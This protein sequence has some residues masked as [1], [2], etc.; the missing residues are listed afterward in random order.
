[1][2]V[3]CN[4]GCRMGAVGDRK[5]IRCMQ[6]PQLGRLDKLVFKSAGDALRQKKI[7]VIGAGPAGLEAACRLAECG[8]KPE[9]Y[10]KEAR[11]GGLANLAAI[12]PHKENMARVVS[13]RVAYL[14]QRHVPIH[15][16]EAY[17]LE[18]A[19]S[20]RPDFLFA[21]T[22]GKP[23]IPKLPGID[24]P[25]VVSGDDVLRGNVPDGKRIAVLGG[26]LIGCETAEY[27]ATYRHKDVEIMEMREDVA[28]DL[29]KS[30]RSFM[31]KRMSD[32]GIKLHVNVK[33]KELALPDI[34][35]EDASGVTAL[36]GFDGVV[37]AFGRRAERGLID[38]LA[39]SDF[40]GKVY[41]IGDAQKPSFAIDAISGAAERVA[42]F[43]KEN[44]E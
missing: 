39:E 5:M 27:L 14:E 38:Q 40:N 44:D 7:V 1:M 33:V 29:V 19:L 43:M 24:G 36:H 8:L 32:L 21:A 11:P 25:G 6:N 15:Y 37:V 30:R 31:L 2:C 34:L 12:P 13:C 41:E 9:V 4:Q 18:K 16:G 20:E 10:E 26:G 17:T 22:G 42:D 28:I 23:L 35:V 3:G